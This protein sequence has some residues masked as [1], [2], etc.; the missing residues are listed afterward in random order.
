MV[1]LKTYTPKKY[2]FIF[3][4]MLF[5]IW[6]N[7]QQISIPCVEKMPNMPEPYKMRNW[8]KVAIGFDKLAFDCDAKGQYLPLIKWYNCKTNTGK[9]GF[10]CLRMW[11]QKF[12]VVKLLQ[13]WVH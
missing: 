9:K 7:C 12:L 1:W 3:S 10:F 4:M 6:G 13:Q 5:I 2:L 11:G 8:K